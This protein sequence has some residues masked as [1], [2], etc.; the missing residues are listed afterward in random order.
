[1]EMVKLMEIV[2]LRTDS[3]WNLSA[4]LQK[5][6]LSSVGVSI[7]IVYIPAFYKMW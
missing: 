4:A 1:M 6:R 2:K 5:V 3:I 7:T